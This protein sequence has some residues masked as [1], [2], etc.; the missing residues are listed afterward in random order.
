M[1][2]QCQG[3]DN[4]VGNKLS[5]DIC[6]RKASFHKVEFI[7]HGMGPFGSTLTLVNGPLGRYVKYQKN[8]RL[9]NWVLVMW[10]GT[11]FIPK[12]FGIDTLWS[13]LM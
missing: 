9:Y 12:Y 5:L 2:L 10:T 7:G 4:S 6:F 3:L 1:D 13:F 11:E 8:F